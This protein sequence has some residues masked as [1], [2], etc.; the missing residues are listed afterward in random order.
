ML[1][2][3]INMKKLIILLCLCYACPTYAKSEVIANLVITGQTDPSTCLSND[4]SIHFAIDI[5][6]GTYSFNYYENGSKNIAVTVNSGSFSLTGL[7]EATYSSF[8]LDLEGSNSVWTNVNLKAYRLNV[9]E[10]NHPSL[11]SPSG[12]GNQDGSVTISTSLP[13][14]SYTLTVTNPSDVSTD[15]PIVVS[16]GEFTFS[17][18]SNGDYKFKITHGGC[19]TTEVSAS[20]QLRV[21]MPLVSVNPPLTCGRGLVTFSTPF[22]GNVGVFY[23]PVPKL[24]SWSTYGFPYLPINSGEIRIP[25]PSD[26]VATNFRYLKVH[27]EG[28][29]YCDVFYMY[30]DTLTIT[31]LEAITLTLNEVTSATCDGSKVEAVFQTNKTPGSVLRVSY[32]HVETDQYNLSYIFLSPEGKFTLSNLTPGTYNNFRYTEDRPGSISNVISCSVIG[33]IVITAPATPTIAFVSSVHPPTCSS[34]DGSITLSTNLADGSYFF[35]YKKNGNAM[36]ADSVIVSSGAIVVG[37]LGYGTY[38]DFSIT[39]NSC[40]YNLSSAVSLTCPCPS[41]INLV[42][43][44]DDVSAGNHNKVAASSLGGKIMASNKITG[45]AKMNYQAATVE[46]NPGFMAQNGTVF[47]AQTGGCN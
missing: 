30:T 42:S 25:V 39:Q 19:V 38:S 27:Q 43:P 20:L 33:D 36:A 34:N 15:F 29:V 16:S 31:P 3:T 10:I 12:C 40:Q 7:K 24:N 2:I 1:K 37:S 45:T 35:N 32:R 26:V 46:L 11:T 44:T 9:S 21:P 41:V 22:T 17:S 13:D 14:G 47:M 23:D 18:L 5:P 28:S 4:G 6:D 8:W